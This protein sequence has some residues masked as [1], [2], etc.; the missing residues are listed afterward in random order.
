MIVEKWFDKT[1]PVL[2]LRDHE[3]GLVY[4]A[5][6]Q[7]KPLSEQKRLLQ[8]GGQPLVPLRHMLL[9]QHAKRQLTIQP[10]RFQR[11]LENRGE[12]ATIPHVR[13]VDF[14]DI[15]TN[16]RI[17]LNELTF[18]GASVAQG[19]IDFYGIEIAGIVASY[20]RRLRIIS[21]ENK[22]TGQTAVY[23][24]KLSQGHVKYLSPDLQTPENAQETLRHFQ[25]KQA[26]K[27]RV[28]TDSPSMTLTQKREDDPYEKE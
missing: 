8:E 28:A 19:F 27:H 14:S 17:L 13:A 6:L 21:E 18:I 25:K 26:A 15:H 3:K 9:E 12:Q 20:E 7:A 2:I 5:A 24:S 16:S 22:E 11:F 10:F 23:I 1:S 4:D